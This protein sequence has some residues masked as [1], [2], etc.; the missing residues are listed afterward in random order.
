VIKASEDKWGEGE[1]KLESSTDQFKS[2]IVESLE[3]R[4]VR[5][6]LSTAHLRK[7]FNS[8]LL[9]VSLSLFLLFSRFYFVPP[10]KNLTHRIYVCVCVFNIF[11]L[12]HS[13]LL[14]I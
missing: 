7:Y 6:F 8:F 1:T 2:D 9:S 13:T 3:K 11:S 14:N 12:K 10:I 5:E 4:R